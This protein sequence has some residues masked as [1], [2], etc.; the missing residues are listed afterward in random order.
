M[1]GPAHS[2][3]LNPIEHVWNELQVAIEHVW[4]MLQV[5]ISRCPVEP[6]T[7]IELGNVLTE[8]WDN[9]EMAATQRLVESTR[10]RCQAVIASRGSHTSY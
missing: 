1:S 4:D 9:L 8:E 2:P 10:R 7:P 6:T 3:D 5:A